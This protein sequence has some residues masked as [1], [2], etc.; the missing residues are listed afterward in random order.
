VG[1]SSTKYRFF[2]FFIAALILQ[3]DAWVVVHAGGWVWWCMQVD[4]CG[5][6][7][8]WMGVVVHAGGWKPLISTVN[9]QSR[10]LVF[11][12]ESRTHTRAQ[13]KEVLVCE[14]DGMMD[15]SRL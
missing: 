5:G 1:P 12:G 7:C 10:R 2:D 15:W 8:R 14:W 13:G 4:G 3:V 11:W 6:A 9:M